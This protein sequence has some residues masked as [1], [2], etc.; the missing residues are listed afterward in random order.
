MI[1]SPSTILVHKL[2]EIQEELDAI[3]NRFVELNK[4]KD[5]LLEVQKKYKR[6]IDVINSDLGNL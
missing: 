2:E 3:E 6:L 5:A 4:E 1:E